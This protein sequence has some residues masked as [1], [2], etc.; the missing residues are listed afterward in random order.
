MSFDAIDESIARGYTAGIHPLK[1][2][3]HLA[4]LMARL[5]AARPGDEEFLGPVRRH[6]VQ[7]RIDALLEMVT[8]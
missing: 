7:P 3:G 6:I 5:E 1:L 8:S 4:V 2:I